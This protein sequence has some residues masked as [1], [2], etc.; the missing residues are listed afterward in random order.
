MEKNLGDLCLLVDDVISFSFIDVIIK[1][2]MRT[3]KNGYHSSEN[4]IAH[5]GNSLLLLLAL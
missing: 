4:L 1:A 3:G 5:L 2:T